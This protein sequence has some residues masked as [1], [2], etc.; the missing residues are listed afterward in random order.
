MGK[1]KSKDKG[2]DFAVDLQKEYGKKAVKVIKNYLQN[3]GTG[4]G[5][6][7]AG[8]H[9]ALK[10]WDDHS[11]NADNDLVVNRKKLAQRSH[12][13]FMDSPLANGVLKDI[14]QNVTGGG[15][16]L[17]GNINYEYLGISHEEAREL[18][19]LIEFE[20]GVW[21][22]NSYYCDLEGSKTFDDLQV[23]AMLSVLLSGDVF[24][25]TPLKTR[26]DSVYDLKIKLISAQRVDDPS[27]KEPDKNILNGI[28]IDDNGFPVAYYVWNH[29][30]EDPQYA[31]IE[32]A[33]FVRVSA[34]GSLTSRRNMLHLFTAERPEQRRG[35]PVLSPIIETFKQLNRYSEAEITAAVVSGMFSVFITKKD[36]TEALL[37]VVKNTANARMNDVSI[38]AEQHEYEEYAMKPGMAMTLQP[39]EKIETANPGR[40]NT[41]F[42]GFVMSILKQIAVGLGLPPEFMLKNMNS[43]YSASRAAILLAW[44]MFSTRRRWLV[45][46]FCQPIYELWLGEA[47]SKGRVNMPGFF[48]DSMIRA[49]W[50]RSN[51]V[52]S[53]PIQIDPKK[54]VEAAKMRIEEGLTTREHEA[55][56]LTG[57][58]FDNN[59]PVKYVEE[60]LMDTV[61][62]T[63]K[64]LYYG[65]VDA[66][67]TIEDRKGKKDKNGNN[68]SKNKSKSKQ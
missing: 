5:R 10:G 12:S 1:V 59:I 17:K 37:E 7:G 47:V 53:R 26:K 54:D 52:G 44:E 65:S 16:T 34:F 11:S 2:K 3:S 49:A 43:S 60:E 15:L 33:K 57:L 50:S 6:T 48:N 32:T 27:H 4:Y 36:P 25:A 31:K 66:N 13:L 38:P 58:S 9:A 42:D 8:N 68:K 40:P 63:E 35:I 30:P 61:R 64:V 62:R 45:K 55:V 56:E 28:E 24:V 20:F 18:E 14:A 23:L 21:A 19:R 46:S 39:G 22:S 29:L 41:A 51:W 67:S